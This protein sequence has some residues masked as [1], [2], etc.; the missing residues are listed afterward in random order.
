MLNNQEKLAL[1]FIDECRGNMLIQD[2]CFEQTEK[3]INAIEMISSILSGNQQWENIKSTI[4]D[5]LESAFELTKQAYFEYGIRYSWSSSVIENQIAKE[6][7]KKGK[8]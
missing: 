5:C 7:I 8:I 2:E 6:K 4:E 3:L 1:K